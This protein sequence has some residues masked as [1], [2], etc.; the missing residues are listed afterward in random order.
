MPLRARPPV[1]EGT[2]STHWARAPY[3]LSSERAPT[4]FLGCRAAGSALHG[5]LGYWSSTRACG[6][7]VGCARS[8]RLTVL[9]Y[10]SIMTLTTIG[11]GDVIP[12]TNEER[13][14][15]MVR[16][17]GRPPTDAYGSMHGAA[18]R[19]GLNPRRAETKR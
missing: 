9:R 15:A 13:I 3:R 8:A 12:Q 17:C 16:V 11:Y 6:R 1:A 4:A 10:W 2:P 5:V 14:V 19:C 7:A 18:W